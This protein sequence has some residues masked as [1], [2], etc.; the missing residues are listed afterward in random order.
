[1][2]L[3]LLEIPDGA[4]LA[5]GGPTRLQRFPLDPPF[6]VSPTGVLRL[7]QM[8]EAQAWQMT[9]ERETPRFIGGPG[10][11]LR[12]VEGDLF[13]VETGVD[14][15]SFRVVTDETPRLDWPKALDEPIA[16]IAPGVAG[17][18]VLADLLMERQHP[19]GERLRSL[20]DQRWS[21][22]AWLGDLRHVEW[23]GRLDLSWTRGV[24]TGAVARTL[25]GLD[26][27]SV[28]VLAH[29]LQRVDVIAW[30][31]EVPTADAMAAVL[32]TL[33]VNRL[34][35]LATLTV[36]GLKPSVGDVL[37]RL[38]RQGRWAASVTK[39][40]SFETPRPVPLTLRTT[41]RTDAVPERG[42]MQVGDGSPLCFVRLRHATPELTVTR[43]TFTLNGVARTRRDGAS[44]PWVVPLKRD[45]TFTVD[46]RTYTLDAA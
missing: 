37:Q 2:V 31:D 8:Q 9:L 36:H 3:D 25:R 14:M 1:M 26:L 38:W 46:E 30:S 20:P 45:D 27:L 16:A 32:D 4:T 18:E 41:T 12:S 17:L 23:E 11:R 43:P 35:W 42:Y 34:P 7:P 15:T 13:R 5:S 44:G 29:L 22:A 6:I 39:G 19:L 40:C 28:H 21:D 33:V 10:A 24:V